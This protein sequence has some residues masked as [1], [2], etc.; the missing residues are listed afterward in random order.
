[1]YDM[2]Y[3]Q[4][5]PLATFD[6]LKEAMSLIE[7]NGGIRPYI[8]QWYN[9]V[10]LPAYESKNEPDS[11]EATNGSVSEN[12][13]AVTTRY[14]IEKTAEV[15]NKRLSN[16]EMLET[17]LNPLLNLNVISSEPSMLDRR[18][19]IYYPVKTKSENKN[20]FDFAT[21][22]NNSQ[23]F[24]IKVGNPSIYPDKLY[25]MNEIHRVL[26]YSS[27][28]RVKLVDQDGIERSIQEIVDRYHTNVD[29]CFRTDSRSVLHHNSIGYDY[30][31][32]DHVSKE[33]CYNQVNDIKLQSN[34]N[35]YPKNIIIEN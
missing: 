9:E 23:Y 1:M 12:R 22:N 6:D 31:I 4:T 5:V 20:L 8:L 33:Y 24:R 15:Q 14:L 2:L 21:S 27:D 35:S 25:I 30:L 19:N 34:I 17:Y 3:V 26:K 10:F 28:K 7:H 13:I 32:S 18:A 16:K 29:E 11:K